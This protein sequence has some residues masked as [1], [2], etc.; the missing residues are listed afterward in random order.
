M[1][2]NGLYWAVRA[3]LGCTGLFHVVHVI[4]VIQGVK[5]FQWNT[6][7]CVPDDLHGQ[8]GRGD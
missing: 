3:V 7:P 1:V 8:V 4:P 2:Y 6:V 5:V